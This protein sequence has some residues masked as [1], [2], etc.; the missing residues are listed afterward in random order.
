MK[1]LHT[2]AAPEPILLVSACEC[3]N[4]F[5]IVTSTALT[6]YRSTTLTV[7]AAVPLASYCGTRAPSS[8]A[9]AGPQ[10]KTSATGAIATAESDWLQASWSPSGRLFTLALPSGM[11]LVLD[12]EGG[13]LVRCFVPQR[14]ASSSSASP[15]SLGFRDDAVLVTHTHR[16]VPQLQLSTLPGPVAALAWTTVGSVL[17][18]TAPDGGSGTAA[19]AA[20]PTTSSSFT[21]NPMSPVGAGGG[22]TAPLD[23]CLPLPPSVSTPVLEEAEREPA[24]VSGTAPSPNAGGPASAASTGH[25]LKSMLFVLDSV[26]GLSCVLGGLQEVHRVTLEVPYPS[27]HPSTGLRVRQL[28]IAPQYST[29]ASRPAEATFSF[30]RFSIA[31]LHAFNAACDTTATPSSSPGSAA[32]AVCCGHRGYVVVGRASSAGAGADPEDLL[33]FVLGDR[34]LQLAQP[35][36]LALCRIAEHCRTAQMCLRAAQHRWRRLLRHTV[37]AHLRLPEKATLLRDAVVEEVAQPNAEKLL[38]YYKSLP[39]DALSE[40]LDRLAEVLYGVAKTTYSVTYRCYDVAIHLAAVGEGAR[41]TSR[42][43]S[44]LNSATVAAAD[45]TDSEKPMPSLMQ[46]LGM[47]RR[48]AELVM[49]R[50]RFEADHARELLRW[51]LQRAS[52]L[53]MQ[54]SAVPV[55]GGPHGNDPPPIDAVTLNCAEEPLAVARHANLLRSLTRIA[56][57]ESTA[58]VPALEETEWELDAQLHRVIQEEL[59]RFTAGHERTCRVTRLHAESASAATTP[60]EEEKTVSSAPQLQMYDVVLPASHPA[61]SIDT[62]TRLPNTSHHG[63]DE[64]SEITGVDPAFAGSSLACEAATLVTAY[65]L[66]SNGS[67]ASPPGRGALFLSAYAARVPVSRPAQPATLVCVPLLPT[68]AEAE[69]DKEEEVQHSTTA[70]AVSVAGAMAHLQ[71]TTPPPQQQQRVVRYAV[72]RGDRH[73]LLLTRTSSAVPP[74]SGASGGGVVS[75]KEKG[76]TEEDAF[77]LA[78]CDNDGELIENAAEEDDVEEGED[79]GGAASSSEPPAPVLSMVEVKG[80]AVEGPLQLSVSRTREFAV[81]VAR[82]KFVVVDLYDFS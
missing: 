9:K 82:D 25:T 22:A 17:P 46:L 13:D 5:A 11:V 3:V 67:T 37:Y 41:L 12:V 16:R 31:A 51:V 34:L 43:P 60:G 73:V 42:S 69:E 78:V 81:V 54:A 50:T 49:H 61:M 35:R 47:L 74:A 57:G 27:L 7:V 44:H 66:S 40:D 29:A 71:P 28:V 56:H 80:V 30:D 52:L 79:D 38:R 53:L 19:A 20:V 23:T 70:E 75:G 36:A 55:G 6:V 1:I 68:D 4:L 39:R 18:P 58:W 63:G 14:T 24:G 8:D 77:V 64:E 15:S 65:A 33:E 32:S 10:R 76:A 2:K 21:V 72:M 26:A 59:H 48:R 62:F 45:S